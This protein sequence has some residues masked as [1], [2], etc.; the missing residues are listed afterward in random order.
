MRSWQ[1]FD[2]IRAEL[3]RRGLIE[4]SDHFRDVPRN[5]HPSRP[6]A[7]AG[8]A[9]RITIALDIWRASTGRRNRD[10]WPWAL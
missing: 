2:E 10:A 6:P 8:D 1:G 5:I 4:G 3:Q 7:Q 9:Q